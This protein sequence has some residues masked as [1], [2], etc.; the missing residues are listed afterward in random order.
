LLWKNQSI[1]TV[2]GGRKEEK[3]ENV[4]CTESAIKFATFV[5]MEFLSVYC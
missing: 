5:M 4:L 3:V 1:K 2:V